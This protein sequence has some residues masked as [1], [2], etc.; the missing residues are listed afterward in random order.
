MKKLKELCSLLPRA[1]KI[2]SPLD[3]VVTKMFQQTEET[4]FIQSQSP[5]GP[6]YQLN[7]DQEMLHHH[8]DL[9]DDF[10]QC[11]P[12]EKYLINKIFYSSCNLVYV[13][14]GIGVGKTTFSRYLMKPILHRV[15]HQDSRDP[16]KCPGPIY[17]DFLHERTISIEGKSFE[18]VQQ[19][20][21]GLFCNHIE[22]KI[23]AKEYFADPSQEVEMVWNAGIA[24]HSKGDENNPALSYIVKRVFEEHAKTL[25]LDEDVRREILS[26]REGIRAEL[27][28]N[29]N[30]RGHY[31]AY[32]LNY[33]HDK[34]YQNHKQCLLI[35]VDNIDR[36]L[37]LVQRAVGLVLKPFAKNSKVR[38]VV[39]VRQTTYHQG[40]GDNLSETVDWVGYCGP[41][42]LTVITMRLNQFLQSPQ[43]YERFYNPMDLPVLAKGIAEIKDA[44]LN[45][46]RFIQFF[47]ALSG[48]SIR[49]AL[50]LAQ[51]LILNSIYDPYE[52]GKK[53]IAGAN[54]RLTDVLRALMVGVGEVYTYGHS[55][56]IENVFEVQEQKGESP[57]TKLRILRT[58]SISDNGL[59][60]N[61]L[62]NNL[63]GFKYSVDLIRDAFNDMLNLHKRLIWSDSVDNFES[64]QDL[65]T[66]GSSRL[67]ISTAG[68]GYASILCRQV[69]YIQEVMLDTAV[70]SDQISHFGRDYDYGK[71]EARFTMVSRFCSFLA[72]QDM[73]EVQH[74]VS[75]FGAKAYKREFGEGSLLS[76]EI[77]EALMHDIGRILNYGIDH[78]HGDA[79]GARI[80]FKDDLMTYF[81]DW[82]FRLVEFEKRNLETEATL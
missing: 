51:S 74:F 34:Y 49:K 41:R 21:F 35:I 33:I 4:D 47:E 50:L 59:K 72:M 82:H 18:D 66:L 3:N 54:L 78:T 14:G 69:M 43:D 76:R 31:L 75:D 10:D 6:R 61:K 53:G 15:R 58:L 16:S 64:V 38:I 29:A 39:N 60:V 20:F 81:K 80:E 68:R 12:N 23:I 73:K 26:R 17:F 55:D 36:E 63:A 2:H 19:E 7:V 22:A 48:N 24:A 77:L 79:R 40:Q 71:M 5:P 32:L 56:I 13:V 9:L 44:F 46:D 67:F 57:L 1:S 70:S 52:V 30:L 62:I 42:P 8:N 65:M 37:A 27:M 11:G 45:T 28:S 25:P